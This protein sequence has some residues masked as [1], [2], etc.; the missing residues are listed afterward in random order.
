M[1][2]KNNITAAIGFA[3]KIADMILGK[4]VKIKKFYYAV[5]TYSIILVDKV[6]NLEL[7]K[8]DD[9]MPFWI[10]DHKVRLPMNASFNFT[11]NS[12]EIIMD[13]ES[14]SSILIEICE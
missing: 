2:D 12:I 9:D 13:E 7:H 11:N 4:T 14:K 10:N 6:V 8:C 5:D 1:E 3:N